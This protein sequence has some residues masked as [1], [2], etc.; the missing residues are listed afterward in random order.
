MG[1]T[2]QGQCSGEGLCSQMVG[3]KHLNSA[4]GGG[5]RVGGKGSV[6][7]GKVSSARRADAGAGGGSSVEGG[8][9]QPSATVSRQQAGGSSVG[10]SKRAHNPQQGN[11]RAGW[12][13]APPRSRVEKRSAVDRVLG[14]SSHARAWLGPEMVRKGKKR[15]AAPVNS[16]KKR[17]KKGYVDCWDVMDTINGSSAE[18][19]AVGRNSS[20]AERRRAFKGSSGFPSDN[21]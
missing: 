10:A 9:R 14:L 20:A 19:H 3:T 12:A 17:M 8:Q 18:G 15:A 7:G 21:D 4:A 13:V 5:R 16:Q 11:S 6:S 2:G 1:R